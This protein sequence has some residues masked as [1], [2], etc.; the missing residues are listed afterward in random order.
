[1]AL[2]V[3]APVGAQDVRV[4]TFEDAVDLALERNTD[5]LRA[6]T[7]VELRRTEETREWMDFLPEVSVATRARRSFGRSFS[8]EEGAILSESNDIVDTGLTAT[9]ELFDGLERV[10]SVRGA[11]MRREASRLRLER[12]AEDVLF[13]VVQG[14]TE[15]ALDRELARVRAEELVAEEELLE[16][17]RRLVDLGR[18]PAS[19]LYQQE[20]AQAE[21]EAALV[22]ARRQVELTESV[23]LQ[24]LELDPMERHEFRTPPLPAGQAEL[25]YEPAELLRLALERRPDLRALEAGLEASGQGVTAARAGYWPSLSVSVDYGSNWSSNSLQPVPGTGSAPRQVTLMP[26]SGG[27]PVTLEVPGTGSSP[28][29]RRPDFFEQL[30]GRRGGSVSLS[31]S[32]PVFDRLQTRLAVQRAEVARRNARYDLQDRRQEVAVQV[33]QSI[34]E[35]RSA[36]A[37][38][39]ATERRL[40]AAERAWAAAERRYELGAATFVEVAQARS[41]LVS[42]RSAALRARFGVELA[43]RLIAYHT[44]T[45]DPGTTLFTEISEDSDDE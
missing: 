26:E 42:A 30:D 37:R 22:D 36:V 12:T 31:L 10:A 39:A 1:M 8:R 3:G 24:L 35:H 45:L 25:R 23:L 43:R 17:V 38:Q 9:V 5:L 21:A 20:A 32:L 16:Q 15:L 18:Q 27:D 4:V 14:Y 6:R 41:A 2:A 13:Q 19:D 28:E 34:L 29:L 7:D 11:S 33:R 40:A 44:G